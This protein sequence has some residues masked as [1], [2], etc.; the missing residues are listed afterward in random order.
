MGYFANGS[1]GYRYESQ[2]CKRCVHSE[3]T[4]AVLE[5]HLAFNY[6]QQ[7]QPDLRDALALLIPRGPAGGNGR[8]RMFLER[9]DG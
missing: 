9:R 2:W 4:C 1:E 8:C 6:D 3:P 5:A 7:R